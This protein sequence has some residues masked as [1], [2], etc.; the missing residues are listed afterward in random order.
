MRVDRDQR[1][2][3]LDAVTENRVHL[4]VKCHE[5]AP[6]KLP[7]VKEC[8]NTVGWHVDRSEAKDKRRGS[9]HKVAWGLRQP[10]VRLR[11]RLDTQ[12]W[13]RRRRRESKGWCRGHGE[14]PTARGG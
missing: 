9:S 5:R 4:S 8:T 14:L 6:E 10:I 13:K 3:E 2:A 1:V 12:R 11:R 7:V